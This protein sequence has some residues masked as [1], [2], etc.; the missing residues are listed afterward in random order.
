MDLSQIR[1][2]LAVAQER[3]FTKASKRLNLSQ[4]SISLKVK[5]L[6][7]DLGATLIIREQNNLHLSR[8]GH[9]AAEKLNRVIEDI[10]SIT[11]YFDS[12]K[13]ES[14]NKLT[15]Y[16]T[17]I[18]SH[19]V[20]EKLLLKARKIGYSGVKVSTQTC[21]SEAKVLQHVERDPHSIGITSSQAASPLL[22]SSIIDREELMLICNKESRHNYDSVDI[23]QLFNEKLWL[24][25]LG[26]DTLKIFESKIKPLGLDLGD[27]TYGEHL[28]ELIMLDLIRSSEDIGIG[29][30][31]RKD[32]SSKQFKLIRINE[33]STPYA[34]YAH[35]HIQSSAVVQALFQSIKEFSLELEG[36]DHPVLERS[37]VHFM[38]SASTQNTTTAVRVGIQ[39]RTIQAVVAGRAIQKLGLYESFLDEL[40][41][42]SHEC[43]STVF[44]D[45]QSAAPILT[46][47][48]SGNLDIAIAGDYAITHIAN[49]LTAEEEKIVLIGFTSI[50]PMGSGSRLMIPQDAG[51]LGLSGLTQQSIQVPLLSTAHGSL[52]YNL[53]RKGI[54]NSTKIIDLELNLKSPNSFI[55]DKTKSL[56]CFTPFDHFLESEYGYVKM[57]D[58]MSMPFS[59][60]GVIARLNFITQ[61]PNAVVAFLKSNLC[62]NHWFRTTP[63]AI[64]HLSKWTGVEESIV[65]QII[66][67][68]QGN[69]CHY[70]HDTTIRRDWISEFTSTL[71]IQ[72][73]KHGNRSTVKSPLV[74]ED[75]LNQARSELSLR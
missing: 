38:H 2:F 9:F 13:E 37:K 25:E 3:S 44:K 14:A 73:E 1:A 75:F 53:H 20:V 66:G 21:E 56:A 63:S 29:L 41:Q 46:E 71:F 27:F 28:S 18:N 54:L 61:H 47:L 5:A 30:Y 48:K 6:E 67:E 74:I 42:T 58:E 51:S 43:Y 60:Y 57:E 34:I 50:N 32:D 10:N 11:S 8:E 68:R 39:S 62:S 33:F 49:S 64:Q 70:M 35:C 16:H 26:S 72:D 22:S 69:D 24:P 4:P 55:N 31:N 7:K 19:T 12:L 65:N 17:P 52:L 59:F 15:I 36:K 23:S 45:Y 40:H